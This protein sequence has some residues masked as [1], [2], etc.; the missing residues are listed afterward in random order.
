MARV[1]CHAGPQHAEPFFDTIILSDITRREAARFLHGLPVMTPD[2][3]ADPKTDSKADPKTNS[4][5][6]PGLDPKTDS[7]AAPKAATRTDPD[8]AIPL[9]RRLAAR[10]Q[11]VNAAATCVG[12]LLAYLVGTYVTGPFHAASHWMGAMLACTSV[13]VVL[14]K[15]GLKQSLPVGWMRVLGTFIGALIAFCYLSIWHFSV[16]GMLL[17][18]F[19]LEIV[20]MLLGI[21]VNGHI[22]TITLIVILLI[23]QENPRLPPAINCLLRFLESVVGVGIGLGVMWVSEWWQQ[24]R[25]RAQ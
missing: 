5:A 2:S 23:S 20:S 14:Q 16:A 12:V 15:P 25:H 6:D 7:T 22:A 19:L 1:N 10:I 9:W 18:I 21:Y 3:K 13:V 17:T 8:P 4:K 24:H 11:P